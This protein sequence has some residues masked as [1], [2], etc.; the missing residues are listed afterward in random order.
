MLSKNTKIYVAGHRGM[1]GFAITNNLLNKGY[2]DLIL[3]T[4]EQL[5]LTDQRA[6]QDFFRNEKIDYVVMAAAKVCGIHAN[7]TY[8]ADFIYRNIMIEAN[9]IHGAYTAGVENLMFLGSSCIYPQMAPQPMR[10]GYLLSGKLEPTNEPYAIAKIAGIKLCAAYNRQHGTNYRCVMPTNLYGPN[11]NYDLEN[12]HVLPAFI[13]KFHLAKL[14]FAGDWEGVKRDELQHGPI[15][16][17]IIKNLINIS[18]AKGHN[19]LPGKYFD[20]GFISRFSNIKDN[21]YVNNALVL[22]GSGTPLR[23]FLH[24]GDMASATVFVMELENDVFGS[25][26]PDKGLPFVNVGYGKDLSTQELAGIVAGVVGYKG[27]VVW[28]Q[29]KEDGTPKKLLDISVLTKA[30]WS[31]EISLKKGINM[32]YEEYLK[33]ET[34]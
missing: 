8:P 4:H 15:P 20:P 34:A 14:A 23:E 9:L 3:Q 18:Q 11:D 26:I 28:D 10:E 33:E 30:G 16:E 12:S 29:S 19:H 1:A 22:W 24:V 5:D 6:V 31:P 17:N 21:A 25:L 7:N 13:R 27:K 2:T 32:T